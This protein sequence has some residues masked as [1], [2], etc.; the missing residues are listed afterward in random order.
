MN[1]EKLKE[2]YKNKTMEELELIFK[3]KQQENKDIKEMI[4]QL[5]DTMKKINIEI[6]IIALSWKDKQINI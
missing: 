4:E 5:D 3:Q 1:I 6:S 2:M